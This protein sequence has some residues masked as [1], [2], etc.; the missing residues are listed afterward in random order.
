MSAASVS[1]CLRAPSTRRLANRIKCALAISACAVSTA[2]F[3]AAR[4][5]A[6]VLVTARPAM[7]CDARTRAPEALA[8]I[9]RI[10]FACLHA[11]LSLI[12]RAP[13]AAAPLHARIKTRSRIRSA[14]TQR[15][16]VTAAAARPIAQARTTAA[17]RISRLQP[18]TERVRGPATAM[19]TNTATCSRA[20]ARQP[21]SAASS[22][23][24][25]K[26]H[27]PAT[28]V[29]P[30]RATANALAAPLVIRILTVAR[31]PR[32]A[33]PRLKV[34][35]A[36]LTGLRRAATR[37]MGHASAVRAKTSA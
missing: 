11:A 19:R 29:R 5:E 12:T 28:P 2:T 8:R 27:A 1:A 26:I 7:Q 35:A 33:L 21:I 24:R 6:A 10:R 20:L 36:T 32:S 31:A 17:S 37:T 30:T 18:A 14:I 25:A 22:T 4:P 23:I 13:R 3:R 9:P 16:P 34:D 15:A